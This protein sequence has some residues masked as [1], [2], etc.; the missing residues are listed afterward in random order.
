MKQ[1][2]FEGFESMWG[3]NV[4]IMEIF[5]Q[6][7]NTGSTCRVLVKIIAEMDLL[8]LILFVNLYAVNG[9]CCFLNCIIV[10]TAVSLFSLGGDGSIL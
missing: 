8:T 7:L 6:S 5:Q 3:K 9:F 10:L 2:G 4:F 1:I